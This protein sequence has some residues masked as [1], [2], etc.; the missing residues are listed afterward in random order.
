MTVAVAAGGLLFLPWIGG[1]LYQ[2]GHTGTPWGSPFRPTAIVQTTFVEMGGG[3]V[4]EA[5]LYG[6]VLLVLSLLGLFAVRA[7]GPIVDL[8]MRTAPTVRWELGGGDPRPRRRRGHRVC[9]RR[10]VP[11]PV[12]RDRRAPGAPCRRRRPG[13]AAGNCGAGGRR[14]VRARSRCSASSGSTTTSG[15]SRPTWPRPCGTG[16]SPATWWCTAPTSW[17]PRTRGRCPT[18]SSRWPTRPWARPTGSTGS[19]TPSATAPPT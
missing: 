11:G 4:T 3:S 10:H 14:G 1:F 19:T 17:A 18:A 7:A 9:H 5:S 13:P 16:R 8:D 15:P 6:G 2:S 12:R